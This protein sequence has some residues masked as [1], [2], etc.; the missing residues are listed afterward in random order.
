MTLRESAFANGFLAGVHCLAW[1]LIFPCYWFLD[2]LISVCIPTTKERMHRREQACYILPLKVI[3]GSLV[4]SFLFLLTSP[5]ALIGFL[6]WVPLQ[7]KRRPFVYFHKCSTSEDESLKEKTDDQAVQA[8]FGFLTA[9]LCLLPDCLAR[10]NNLSDT[11]RRSSVI[12]QYIVQGV[13][14]PRIKIYV[15][16]PSSGTLSHGSKNSLITPSHTAGGCTDSQ[17]PG[18]P[19]LPPDSHVS[20]ED[21]NT[22]LVFENEN[23]LNTGPEDVTIAVSDNFK[24]QDHRADEA[25]TVSDKNS[26]QNSNVFG[27]FSHKLKK[28]GDVP[29]EISAHFPASV[30]FICL[31]EV[32]DKRAA[33]KLKELLSPVFNHVLYDVGIY[34]FHYC[35]SFKFFNS[36]IFF[37][38]RHPI[39]DATYHC[40]PNGRG[41]DSLA[42]KGL[43]CVKVQLEHNYKEKKL[44]GYFNCTHLHAPEADGHIRC[45]QMDLLSKWIGEF[46]ARTLR[47]NE[48]V[49]FDVLCGDFNFDNTS[50]DDKSEQN[51]KLFDDYRDPCRKGPGKEKPQVIGTLLEQPKLYKVDSPE[52]LQRVLEDENDRKIFLSPPV[53]LDGSPCHDMNPEAQWVGRRLDYILYREKQFTTEVEEFTFITHLAGLTDHLSVGMRLLVN[54]DNP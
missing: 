29:F 48:N 44:I 30:D 9:N 3:F 38:S 24:E 46:Q 22:C 27:R 15:D 10:F 14:R 35:S 16:S 34:G 18:R 7:L 45:E 40:F 54:M 37:A 28:G 20:I 51:H 52:E 2:R 17:S 23:P 26:N 8:S 43:L 42:A 49:A 12:G 1:A 36:G 41:E 21:D 6:L 53:G 39:L 5:I 13:T 25:E 32:F 31:Q 11:Q 4:F 19:P 33:K 50:P 47:T